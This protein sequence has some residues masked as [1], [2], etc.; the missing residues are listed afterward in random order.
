MPW[1]NA[2]MRALEVVPYKKI[3]SLIETDIIQA[4]EE[5]LAC[6]EL[7]EPRM[8]TISLNTSRYKLTPEQKEILYAE[9]RKFFTLAKRV[10]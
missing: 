2:A 3:E 8:R 9:W 10:I 5:I 4:K 7:I 1:F 6:S